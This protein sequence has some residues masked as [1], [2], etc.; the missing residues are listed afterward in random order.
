MKTNLTT[1]LAALCAILLIVSLV[2]QSKQKNEIESLRQ[3]HDQFV[4]ATTQN[5]QEAKTNMAVMVNAVQQQTA[6]MYRALGKVIPVELP[7]SVS[8]NLA[9]MET[10]IAN[11]NSWPTNSAKANAMLA[12]LRDLLH[13][14]PPWA[15]DDLLPRLKALNW[16]VESI[17]VLRAN[18]NSTNEDLETAAE[19]YADQISIQPDDGSTNLAAKLSAGQKDATAQFETFRQTSAISEATNQLGSHPMTDGLAAWQRLSEWTNSQR[20]IDLRQQLHSRLLNDGIA[21]FIES[22]Q[23][24]LQRLTV[25][26]NSA[27]QQ[28]GYARLLESVTEQRLNVLEQADIS[29]DSRNKLEDFSKTVETKLKEEVDKQNLGYQQLALREIE[30][31]RADFANAQNQTRHRHEKGSLYGWNDWD[32][33]YTDYEMIRDAMVNHLIPISPA[34]LDSA[35]SRLYNEAFEKGWMKL[36]NEK[37]LQTK[38]AKADASTPKKTPQNYLEK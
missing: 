18:E 28:A 32:E 26:T 7:E 17:Q 14:I 3:Q 33:T 9:R 23:D 20:A 29:Q 35:V 15:E 22:S 24:N 31:F 4:S 21:S 27:L 25:V 30:N 16:D 8:N 5:Q 12:E 36:E 38:V 10:R 13:Q 6:V 2:N 37:D 11:E 1:G 34:H 19:A